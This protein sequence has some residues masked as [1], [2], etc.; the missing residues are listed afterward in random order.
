M[1]ED[2]IRSFREKLN[3]YYAWP[4]VY[5]FKFIVPASKEAEVIALFPT[6]HSAAKASKT[7]KYASITFQMM[8]PSADAVIDIYQKAAT[9]EGLIAL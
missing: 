9:V 1:N 6:H 8:M 3:Q 2:A 7:G 4:A 5:T